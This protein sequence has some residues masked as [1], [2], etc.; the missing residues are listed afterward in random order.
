MSAVIQYVG[1]L[2][3]NKIYH[4]KRERKKTV[5]KDQTVPVAILVAL[6]VWTLFV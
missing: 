5:R 4:K 1:K 2:N 3:L 6:R